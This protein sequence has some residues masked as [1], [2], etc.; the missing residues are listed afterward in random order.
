MTDFGVKTTLLARNKILTMVDQEIVASLETRMNVL[1]LDVRLGTP[2]TSVQFIRG[3][4]KRVNLQNGDHVDAQVVLCALGRPTNVDDLK[5]NNAGV[6]IEK[7]V[8]KID[9]Y[10]KTNVPGI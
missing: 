3:G 5:L 10:Q 4:M 6:I 7:G 9:E 2:F 8:I 1:G